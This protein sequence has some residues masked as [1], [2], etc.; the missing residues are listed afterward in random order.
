MD[1][2]ASCY[3]ITGGRWRANLQVYVAD[4]VWPQLRRAG[5]AVARCAVERLIRQ[6]GLRVVTRG[7]VVRTT[8][9]DGAMALRRQALNV[10]NAIAEQVVPHYVTRFGRSQPTRQ[11]AR[12][13]D[14][15]GKDNVKNPRAVENLMT[16]APNDYVHAGKTTRLTHSCRA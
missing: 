10:L 9:S 3:S 4:K 13:L 15:I 8:I 11:H 16:M 14:F 6:H 7:K 5:F 2:K 1:S 12:Q